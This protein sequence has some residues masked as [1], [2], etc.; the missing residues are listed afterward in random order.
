MWYRPLLFSHL[1]P[2]KKKQAAGKIQRLPRAAGRV[3]DPVGGGSLLLLLLTEAGL[4]SEPHSWVLFS[5]EAEGREDVDGGGTGNH[6]S[7]AYKSVPFV[8]EHAH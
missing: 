2:I 8:S 5:S 3:I 4:W 6:L 1:P 7:C